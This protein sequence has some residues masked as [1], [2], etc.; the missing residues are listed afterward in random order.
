MPPKCCFHPGGR[1]C[2]TASSPSNSRYEALAASHGMSAFGGSSSAAIMPLGNGISAFGG[3][4]DIT[5]QVPQTPQQQQPAARGGYGSLAGSHNS[6]GAIRGGPSAAPRQL[7]EQFSG[8]GP[9]GRGLERK[10]TYARLD[11][12]ASR[13][14][15]LADFGSHGDELE[16]SNE[17]ERPQSA[18]AAFRS[19]SLTG[20]TREASFKKKP[21]L[22]TPSKE[23][24]AR[25]KQRAVG[26]AAVLSMSGWDEEEAEAVEFGMQPLPAGKAAGAASAA[27]AGAAGDEQ[28]PSASED[29]P[30]FARPR[31]RRM[32]G[33][34]EEEEDSDAEMEEQGRFARRKAKDAS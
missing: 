4:D 23:A 29:S 12:Q 24:A 7:D 6:S 28:R 33:G 31:R 16:H 8:H 22:M 19:W 15:T 17:E 26:F 3:S 20:G 25:P 18:R 32:G 10:P 30:T 1:S 27:A 9:P 13:P 21:K 5:V 11:R 14:K 34:D 2:A